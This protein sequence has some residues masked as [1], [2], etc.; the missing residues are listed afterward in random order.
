MVVVVVDVVVVEVEVVGDLVD[1]CTNGSLVSAVGE[2]N[3]TLIG[4]GRVYA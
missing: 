3:G 2:G 1:D 4:G